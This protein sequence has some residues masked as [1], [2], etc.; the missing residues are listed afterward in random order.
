MSSRLR[1]YLYGLAMLTIGIDSVFTLDGIC[2]LC[3]FVL[4]DSCLK[5]RSRLWRWLHCISGRQVT[6]KP[7]FGESSD[8]P[9]FLDF[10]SSV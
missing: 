10:V 2:H 8:G 6:A 7:S 5:L 3:R 1:R 9:T 4:E